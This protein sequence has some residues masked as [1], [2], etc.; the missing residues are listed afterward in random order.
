[1]NNLWELTQAREAWRLVKDSQSIQSKLLVLIEEQEKEIALA[2]LE[3]ARLSR[4]EKLSK[5]SDY[6]SK[7]RM[8]AKL[9]AVRGGI[10]ILNLTTDWLEWM[11]VE[12]NHHTGMDK[13]MDMTGPWW[14]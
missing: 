5:I 11:E 3:Q 12:T 8:E 14:T 1:M 10:S 6:W 7:K 4:M 9:E 2:S 13:M